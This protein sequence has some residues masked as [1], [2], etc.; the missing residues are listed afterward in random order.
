MGSLLKVDFK[1]KLSPKLKS[2]NPKIEDQA[3]HEEI[4]I[5]LFAGFPQ[6]KDHVAAYV[7]RHYCMVV[8]DED[9][10]DPRSLLKILNPEEVRM[11][12]NWIVNRS[13]IKPLSL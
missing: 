13:K 7:E 6:F 11:Q 9:H 12:N 2:F 10:S 5:E 8:N 4:F 3:Y 1:V